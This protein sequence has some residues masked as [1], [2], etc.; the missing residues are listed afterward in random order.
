MVEKYPPQRDASAGVYSQ[1]A[2]VV[3]QLRELAD[4]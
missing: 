2:G 3:F 4:H 1:V